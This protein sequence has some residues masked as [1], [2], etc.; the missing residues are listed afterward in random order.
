MD[1]IKE[2]YKS[3]INRKNFVRALYLAKK[4]DLSNEVIKDLAY[5]ALWQVAGIARNFYATKK[6]AE[7]L[8][9]S[10]EEIA[11]ILIK[12]SKKEEESGNKKVI[13]PCYDYRSGKYL[14]FDKWLERLLKEWNKIN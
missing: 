5:K 9:Y 7:D 10:K 8:G 6:L 3:E 4:L 11:E 2:E 12:L 14:S 13:A 1:Y